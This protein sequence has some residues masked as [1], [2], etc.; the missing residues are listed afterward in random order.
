MSTRVR[1]ETVVYGPY[2]YERSGGSSRLLGFCGYWRDVCEHDYPLGNGYRQLNT[3]LMRFNSPDELSPFAEG[4][5]N[6]YMYCNGDPVNKVDSSGRAGTGLTALLKQHRLPKKHLKPFF[7]MLKENNSFTVIRVEGQGATTFKGKRTATG[8][9]VDVSSS[10]AWREHLAPGEYLARKD[11]YIPW[12][13]GVESTAITITTGFKVYKVSELPDVT[14]EGPRRT[15]APENNYIERP[16][17]S[18]VGGVRLGDRGAGFSGVPQGAS[19]S[20]R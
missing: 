17:S 6:A 8:F 19:A 3:R 7:K 9:S 14:L 5:I 4:G 20:R 11:L 16:L 10:V 1:V 2:G 13:E 18:V 15:F 12:R